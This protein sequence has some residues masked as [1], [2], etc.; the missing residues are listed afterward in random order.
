MFNV[1]HPSH[2]KCYINIRHLNNIRSISF[3]YKLFNIIFIPSVSII[4]F[5]ISYHPEMIKL[6]ILYLYRDTEVMSAYI[7]EDERMTRPL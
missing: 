4:A 6:F 7:I 2:I 3:T 5:N 1:W